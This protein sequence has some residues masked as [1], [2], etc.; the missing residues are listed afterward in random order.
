MKILTISLISFLLWFVSM[1]EKEIKLE[2]GAELPAQYIKKNSRMIF[3][4]T[5]QTRPFIKR[6]IKGVEYTIAFD[7][8]NREIRYINT[9]DEDFVTGNNL[10]V[11]SEIDVKKEDFYIIPQIEIRAPKTPDG[12]EPIVGNDSESIEMKPNFVDKLQA[13]ETVKVKI[14]GFSKGGN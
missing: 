6:K 10:R 1:Q 13:N 12:W 7:K 11:G 8:E 14:K 5:N 4:H 3:T 9:Q 2:I